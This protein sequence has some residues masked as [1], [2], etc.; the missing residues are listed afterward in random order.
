[1]VNAKCLMWGIDIF[2]V[3]A[4]DTWLKEHAGATLEENNEENEGG[5][6]NSNKRAG[7]E[8][9][10]VRGKMLLYKSNSYLVHFR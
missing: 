4:D 3:W 9:E 1:M 5:G 10:E 8:V 6:D 7:E 2:S